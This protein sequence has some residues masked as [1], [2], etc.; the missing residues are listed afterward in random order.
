MEKNR[1]LRI[2]IK[3]QI[4]SEVLKGNLKPYEMLPPTKEYAK[5]FGVS[6]LTLEYILQELAKEGYVF[7]I[8]GK[9]TFISPII[10][11]KS[12]LISFIAPDLKNPFIA[13]VFMGIEDS[14]KKYGY[15]LVYVNSEEAS[16]REIF[17]IQHLLNKGIKGILLYPS[18]DLIQKEEIFEKILINMNIP[19]VLVD[20]YF[21]NLTLDFVVS[22]NKNG[23]YVLTKYL[24]NMGHKD[25]AFICSSN[26]A[27]TS[28]KERFEGYR[29]ALREAK[30]DFN[31]ELILNKLSSY[32]HFSFDRD[33]ELVSEFL[34]SKKITAVFCANE[35]IASIVYKSCKL[36]NKDIPDDISVV[37]FGDTTIALY[38]D[39]P[40]TTVYQE[41]SLMGAK[42]VDI[43]MKKI[44]GEKSIT[45][46]YLPTHLVIRNSVKNIKNI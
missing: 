30:I 12:T 43:L 7:R 24:I 35:L 15:D 36:L 11:E 16:E 14:T 8:K 39:P 10:P 27:T 38:L 1:K 45:Q 44:K 32:K 3:E 18:D 21:P 31:E 40:L 13:E 5:K 26:L 22:D 19:I 46:I 29:K 37:G 17:S 23:G 33:I 42:A 34:K 4:K 2:H 6:R 28:V 9:G 41:K 25:I 20:R